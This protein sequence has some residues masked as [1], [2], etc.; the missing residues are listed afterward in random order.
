ME[1]G[2]AAGARRNHRHG[3]FLVSPVPRSTFVPRLAEAMQR[4]A[5]DAELAGRMGALGA[6]KVRAEYDWEKKIDQMLQIYQDQLEPASG[7][8]RAR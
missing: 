3:G 7:A 1:A 2:T 8:A 4:L 6:A 5:N